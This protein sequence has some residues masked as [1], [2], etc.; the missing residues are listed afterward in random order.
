MKDD[1]FV[2]T[3]KDLKG[4]GD[5]ERCHLK[6]TKEM[7]EEIGA[8]LTTVYSKQEVVFTRPS[9]YFAAYG[10]MLPYIRL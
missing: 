7:S 6:T 1:I 5:Q 10:I 9:R 2:F 4:R 8:N 3:C